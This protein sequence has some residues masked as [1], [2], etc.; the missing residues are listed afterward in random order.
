L[1]KL[2]LCDALTKSTDDIFTNLQ[3]Y[4]INED[5]IKKHT[6]DLDNRLKKHGVLNGIAGELI[7][8]GAND[9]EII[10]MKLILDESTDK[11]DR[12]ILFNSSFKFVGITSAEIEDNH[13]IT[14]VNISENNAIKKEK[15]I[16]LNKKFNLQ[17]L[18]KIN[19]SSETLLYKY[20]K[21]NSIELAL[22]N[23]SRQIKANSSSSSLLSIIPA[24]PRTKKLVE[25]MQKDN[26]NNNSSK[27]KKEEKGKLNDSFSNLMDLKITTDILEK[28]PKLLERLAS[29]MRNLNLNSK[30]LN[31]NILK[32]SQSVKDYQPFKDNESVSVKTTTSIRS[33][34]SPSK[35]IYGHLKNNLAAN[36]TSKN[37]TN[38]TSMPTESNPTKKKC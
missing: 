22:K 14:I 32:D 36:E 5:T 16:I 29:P 21:F 31:I 38:V 37:T 23:L 27:N 15:S 6:V 13:N 35:S 25:F 17:K 20:K 24:S 8:Y 1:Q 19:N 11:L 10:V 28:T 26:S 18:H 30:I 12:S 33:F 7:D 2:T 4:E 9:P 34:V 3:K